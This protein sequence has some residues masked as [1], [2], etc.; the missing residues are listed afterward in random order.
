MAPINNDQ[1]GKTVRSRG[2]EF[3]LLADN[4]VLEFTR[5]VPTDPR[6][7]DNMCYF[8]IEIEDL[9]KQIKDDK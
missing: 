3:D 4:D 8:H 5:Q 9:K 7:L 6:S 1:I 2:K